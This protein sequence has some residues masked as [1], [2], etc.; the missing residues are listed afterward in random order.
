MSQT[1]YRPVRTTRATASQDQRTRR[2]H[3]R[4]DIHRPFAT[5]RSHR[6]R[7]PGP[8]VVAPSRPTLAVSSGPLWRLQTAHA[9]EVIKASG[10]EGIEILVT[11]S[12]DTQSPNPLKR[13]ANR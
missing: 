11:Q 9:F 2:T 10:A 8:P 1:K 13:L 12:T 4:S 7:Y 6:R 5:L 3:H